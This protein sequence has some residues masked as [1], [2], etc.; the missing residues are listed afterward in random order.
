LV[1]ATHA[2]AAE[3]GKRFGHGAV[4]SK[5]QAQIVIAE[6]QRTSSNIN[7]PS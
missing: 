3:I 5:I 1:E 6:R 2:A 4:E 7:V